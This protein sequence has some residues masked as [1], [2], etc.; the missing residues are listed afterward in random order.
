MKQIIL[1]ISMM[2]IASIGYSQTSE[3][4]QSQPSKDQQELLDL[5]KAKW[6][7]MSEKKVDTLKKLFDEQAMFV[8]M[9][10]S[11]GKQRELDVIKSGMIWY[12]KAEIYTSSVNIFQNAAILLNE[13]DLV[14]VVGQNEVVNPFMVT[15]VYIK[16]AEGWKLGSL[17]FSKL[18]RPVKISGGDNVPK[19]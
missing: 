16:T 15:E 1:G 6:T 11:W 12:K 19:N 4:K 13:I 5:S 18:N 7:W 3:N 2:L 10:G 9:G 8:H 17:T 14:A